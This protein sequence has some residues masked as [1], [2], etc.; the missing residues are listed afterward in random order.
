MNA[1][2]ELWIWAVTLAIVMLV[3]VPLALYLLWRALKAARSIER[4]TREALQAGVGI[5]NN[6]AAIA[7]LDQTIKSGVRVLEASKLLE[8]R[9]GEIARAVAKPAEVRS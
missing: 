6:T 4:Y 3:I 8:G 2:L 5:A 9:T 7:A 1:P